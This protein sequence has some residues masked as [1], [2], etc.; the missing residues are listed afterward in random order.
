MDTH[1]VLAAI[2]AAGSEGRAVDHP[3]VDNKAHAGIYSLSV[4]EANLLAHLADEVW[5]EFLT[6]DN[7]DA[8]PMS[9][10]AKSVDVE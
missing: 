2:E 4:E 3:E 9:G 7:A 8:L 6:K 10:C 1:T 5:C